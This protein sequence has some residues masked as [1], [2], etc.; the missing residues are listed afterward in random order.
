MKVASWV[1]K[2]S[3]EQP[4]GMGGNMRLPGGSRTVKADTCTYDQHVYKFTLK[5]KVVLF[6]SSSRVES[7]ERT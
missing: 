2:Y 3:D 1:V 6:L 5:G 7:V 4:Y